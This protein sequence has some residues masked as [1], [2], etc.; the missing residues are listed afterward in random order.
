[1]RVQIAVLIAAVAALSGCAKAAQPAPKTDDEKALYA[2]GV[3]MSRN[4][5]TFEFTDQELAMV[6]TGL[7][8][9]ARNKASMDDTAIQALIPKLQELQTKRIAAATT[10]EKAAGTAFVAKAAAEKDA[11][12]TA[13]GLVYKST[14]DGTGATP[15]AEDTVKVHYEGRFVDG[16]VFDSSRERNEPATFPLNGVIPCWTE[17]VQLMKV[18]GKAHVTCPPELAYGDEG[19]P[20][21]MRGGATLVFDIELLGIVDPATAAAAAAAAGAAPGHPAVK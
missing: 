10:R 8:D 3:I 5:Q 19:R 20:P 6:S 11:R 16:K 18:G 12:K 15:K 14:G 9:G 7:A 17:A 4:V 13:S 1:M 2:L 21:Q